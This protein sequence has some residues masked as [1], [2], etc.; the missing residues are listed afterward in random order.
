MPV[1]VSNDSELSFGTPTAVW[2][3]PAWIVVTFGAAGNEQNIELS[4]SPGATEIN[5]EVVIP[6][7]DLDI[8]FA[9]SAAGLD[10]AILASILNEALDEIAITV[11]LHTGDPGTNHNANTIS[12]NGYSDASV[13]AGGFSATVT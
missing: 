5:R 8:N 10:D 7:G 13:S 4:G 12:G 6:A 3:T 11:S 1:N 9:S 2:G